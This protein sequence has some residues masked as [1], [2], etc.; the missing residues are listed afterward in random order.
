MAEEADQCD[1]TFYGALGLLFW[2]QTQTQQ[3][4]EKMLS[5]L[6]SGSIRNLER[7]CNC[8]V[9][10]LDDTEYTCTIQVS[11]CARTYQAAS[12]CIWCNKYILLKNGGIVCWLCADPN[13][14][15]IQLASTTQDR[16]LIITGTVG[17]AVFHCCD[18][19]FV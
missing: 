1:I 14:P 16:S 7:E 8:T 17:R 13:P 9:R 4:C 18:I 15:K 19:G 5:R 3:S 2:S 10:L 6:M 11:R 12:V